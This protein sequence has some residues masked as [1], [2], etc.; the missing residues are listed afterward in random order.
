MVKMK[1]IELKELFH[2]SYGNKFDLNKMELVLANEPDSVSFVARTGKNLGI[3]A[4]VKEISNIQPYEPGSITVALG[5][6]ILSSNI[7]P[8]PFYTAQNI[9]VLNPIKEM[10]FEEKAFY[11]ICIEKNK[12]RYSTFGRE[13]NRT[14]KTLL[15][16]TKVPDW[17][18]HIEAPTF[19]NISDSLLKKEFKLNSSN[20]KWFKYSFLFKIERGR[21]V[22]LKD[23][24]SLGEHPIV[25]AIDNNNGWSGFTNNIPPHNGN[26]ISVARNGNGVGEAFYQPIPFCSTEDVHVFNPRFK[27]NRFIAIFIISLIRKEKFKYNYGR[28]WGLTRMNEFYKTPI[29]KWKSRLGLHGKL[30][31]KLTLFGFNLIIL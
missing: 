29:L 11:C 22:R 30:Y 25:T 26:V 23:T 8:K 6:S 13:A 31:K 17:L 24:N 20:W 4:F 21:G 9:M 5:G 2:L 16:P 12:N 7:Q 3:S 28:K 19:Y 27:L 15:V 14:L 10:S 1:T 18:D